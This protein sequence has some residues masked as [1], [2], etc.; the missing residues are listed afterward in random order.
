MSNL[1]FLLDFNPILDQ[2]VNLTPEQLQQAAQSGVL[3]PDPQMQ[4]QTYLNTLALMGFQTWLNQRDA[5]LSSNSQ[6]Q[7]HH[8]NAVSRLTINDFNIC[9]LT[10][11]SLEEDRIA[12]PQINI[13]QSPDLAHFYIVM[14]VNEENEQVTVTKF[15]DY[16]AL[17]SN[18]SEYAIIL[19]SNGTYIIPLDWFDSEPNNLLL[20]LRCLEGS[21]I[22]L[23]IDKTKNTVPVA[24]KPIVGVINVGKWLQQELDEFAQSLSWI[25]L[26]PGSPAMRESGFRSQYQSVLRELR[27]HGNPIPENIAGGF[28][29]FTLQTLNL[30]LYAF[31]WSENSE[32]ALLLI[33]ATD[34]D[35]FLPD[36]IQLKVSDSE[37][38]LINKRS[39]GSQA[40]L[41]V[42][43]MGELRET[44]QVIISLEDSNYFQEFTF[45]KEI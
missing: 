16:R 28:C 14:Q 2:T 6:N 9:L 30:F 32:W 37:G 7:I 26:P 43:A 24:R 27:D 21:I 12:L 15:I 34:N 39:D 18:L 20:Y 42:T 3:T 10:Q 45:T 17:I 19:E 25:L 13:E 38:L 35:Q 23:P 31:T 40:Y 29:N 11:D 8:L 22:S 33:L 41:S 5:E 44:F 4:W 1:D 36:G